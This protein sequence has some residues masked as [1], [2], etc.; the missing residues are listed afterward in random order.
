M[1]FNSLWEHICA[2]AYA[3]LM[4]AIILGLSIAI[5]FGFAYAF[6]LISA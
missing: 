3:S 2:L 5:C 1:L 6:Y 4:A